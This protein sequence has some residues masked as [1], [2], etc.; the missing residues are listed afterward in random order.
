MFI[1]VEGADQ[2]RAGAM[3]ARQQ[4]RIR[5]GRRIARIH[6]GAGQG[7][8]TRDIEQVLHSVGHAG[9]R[10]QRLTLGAQC[11]DRVGLA[12]CTLNGHR[13]E[14]VQTGI[15]PLDPGLRF[16]QDRMGAQGAIADL[17]SDVG[18][19]DHGLN[20]AAASDANGSG[21]ARMIRATLSMRENCSVISA[22]CAASNS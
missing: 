10:R 2:H 20:T 1:H 12:A 15:A 3:H 14:A 9:Q 16:R 6:F 21:Q 22:I 11:V 18:G 7:H 17:A 5:S 19:A 8:Q 13:C 4:R